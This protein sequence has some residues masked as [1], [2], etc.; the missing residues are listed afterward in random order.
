VEGTVKFLNP[1][2]DALGNLYLNLSETINVSAGK[3]PRKKR[4][5]Q[6]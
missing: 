4:E 5:S 6:E 1:T 3:R 2:T